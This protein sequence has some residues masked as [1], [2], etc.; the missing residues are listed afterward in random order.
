MAEL[1][2]ISITVTGH[3]QGVYYRAYASRIAKALGLRGYVHNVP[4]SG[5][6]EVHAEGDSG[7]DVPTVFIAWRNLPGSLKT[8]RR[9]RWLK[10]WTFNGKISGGNSSTLK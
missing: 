6:V 7:L 1:S 10:I 4:R 9:K 2:R 3:V 5:A 8:A